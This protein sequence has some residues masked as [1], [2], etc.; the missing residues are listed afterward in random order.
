MNHN[1]A[2]KNTFAA[3]GSTS[4]FKLAGGYYQLAA[5]SSNWN[6]GNLKVDQLMPDGTT[7]VQSATLALTANGVVFGYLPPGQFR[8]TLTTTADAAAALA[9][10]PLD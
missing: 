4:A 1:E 6:S 5:T 2:V 10:V 7:W 3:A 9:R 8:L